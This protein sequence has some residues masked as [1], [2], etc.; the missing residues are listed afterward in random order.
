MQQA[1]SKLDNTFEQLLADPMATLNKDDVDLCK[2]VFGF[3]VLFLRTYLGFIAGQAPFEQQEFANM[4]GASVAGLRRWEKGE[5]MPNPMSVSTLASLANTILKLPTPVSPAHLLCRNIIDEL[6]L[7]GLGDAANV[8]KRLSY[9]DK[10]RFSRFMYN[11]VDELLNYYHGKHQSSGIM[12]QVLV[13]NSLVPIFLIQ[14]DFIKFANQPMADLFL[15]NTPDELIGR[16]FWPFIHKDDHALVAK[17]VHDRISGNA[18]DSPLFLKV[19]Q[20]NGSVRHIELMGSTVHHGG[21]PAILGSI[22][23]ITKQKEYTEQLAESER[24]YRLLAEHAGS[25]TVELDTDLKAKYI[26]PAFCKLF[27][28]ADQAD[29]LYHDIRDLIGAEP[30]SHPMEQLRHCITTPGALARFEHKSN[31]NSGQTWIGWSAQATTDGAGDVSGVIM[32]GRDVTELK[33]AAILYKEMDHF[34]NALFD[35]PTNPLLLVYYHRDKDVSRVLNANPAACSFLGYN[36][37]ELLSSELSTIIPPETIGRQRSFFE[38]LLKQQEIKTTISVITK[39]H[40]TKS[41]K[42]HGRLIMYIGRPMILV[43]I[44]QTGKE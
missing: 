23:D 15:F 32:Q 38:V 3:N 10:R 37:Q 2:D 39:T 21:R 22:L 41:V 17:K 13:E 12:Y 18:G 7:L 6:P 29:A 14:D 44:H 9:N 35:M 34:N 33:D 5:V 28:I 25:L 4:L 43:S 27:N 24:V 8:Y 30:G 11:N 26:S 1:V 16:S 19:I 31:T 42:V 40:E 36:K 20:T